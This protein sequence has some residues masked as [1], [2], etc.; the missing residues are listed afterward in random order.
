MVPVLLATLKVVSIVA[1]LS[2][3][4]VFTASFQRGY[5]F[6]LPEVFRSVLLWIGSRSF[7]IYLIHIPAITL[8]HEIW[9]RIN[10]A[11]HTDHSYGW[12]ML[13]TW[14]AMVTVLS[15]L[16]FRLVETPLRRRGARIADRIM[17]DR[18]LLQPA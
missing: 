9:F 17:S 11:S 5:V 6:P 13:A 18:M 8:T 10:P 12:I 16:N 14:L 15:E 3:V 7:A 4:L 1:V 2:A